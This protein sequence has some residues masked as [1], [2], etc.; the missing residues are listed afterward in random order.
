[1]ATFRQALGAITIKSR[2]I[3]RY[4]VSGQEKL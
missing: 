1:M 4:E 3:W 2:A